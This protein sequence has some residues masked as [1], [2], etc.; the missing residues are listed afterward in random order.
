MAAGFPSHVVIALV[1][2]A[3]R[4]AWL[5]R[6]APQVK[7][8]VLALDADNGGKAAM[9]RLANEFRRAGLAVL[10]CPPP[11]DQWGKDWSERWRRLGPA[12]P[13]GNAEKGTGHPFHT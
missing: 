13:A 4:P 12:I 2:T 9:A 6:L 5:V 7:S 1:G 11:H 8:V 3:A 10:L